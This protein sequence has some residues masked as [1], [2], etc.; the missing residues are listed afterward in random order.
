MIHF[1]TITCEE[2]DDD[3]ERRTTVAHIYTWIYIYIYIYE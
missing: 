2:R 3:S 1:W